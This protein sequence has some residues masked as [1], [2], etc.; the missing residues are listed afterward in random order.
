[1]KNINEIRKQRKIAKAMNILK[2][3][4]LN[5]LVYC[6]VAKNKAKE[7]QFNQNKI[8]LKKRRNSKVTKKSKSKALK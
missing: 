5:Y 6:I 1:V 4:K 2:R 7:I 3:R 8:K